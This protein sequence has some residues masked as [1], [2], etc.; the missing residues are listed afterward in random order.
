[1]A[2]SKYVVRNLW[3]AAPFLTTN[4]VHCGVVDA[5][6]NSALAK[7]AVSAFDD[8]TSIRR[9]TFVSSS[10][11]AEA[12]ARKRRRKR[13]SSARQDSGIGSSAT[14]L[15]GAPTNFQQIHQDNRMLT[16]NDFFF[17][18]QKTRGYRLASP[19]I[20]DCDCAERLQEDYIANAVAY[21]LD[22]VCGAKPLAELL[23]MGTGELSID[24]WAAVQR[25]K[26][27]CRRLMVVLP[28]IGSGWSHNTISNNVF[29]IHPPRNQ[30]SFLANRL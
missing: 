4:L 20:A 29:L 6:F 7:A 17:E 16:D 10:P 19:A 24:M 1:M 23:L 30:L 12:P 27:R 9:G 13:T 25:G 14:A 8:Y 11:E 2:S 21:Y 26:V 5:S 22:T 3:N 18:H 15:M 28:R